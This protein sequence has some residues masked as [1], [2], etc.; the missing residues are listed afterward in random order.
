MGTIRKFEELEA[1]KHARILVQEV[2]SITAKGSFSK[3][4]GLL[5]QI[6]RSSVSIMAN[7]AE[8]YERDGT[9]EFIHFLSI[10]KGSAGEV[11]CHLYIARDQDYL[12]EE[13][14]DALLAMT[15]QVSRI[16]RGLI[17]YLQKTDLKGNKFKS[18]KLET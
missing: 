7:I 13:K 12:N 16:I 2:Y 6:R 17:T 8:G 3:D 1:W 15:Q 9:S 5:D 14:F 18:P 4:F 11:R 10:A